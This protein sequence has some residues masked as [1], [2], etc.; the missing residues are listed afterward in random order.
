MTLNAR[1]RQQKLERKKKKRQLVKKTGTMAPGTRDKAR[2]YAKYPVYECLV[3]S[4]IFETGLGTIIVTRRAPSG[5]IAVSAF[6]VDVFCLGVKNAFFKLTSEQDYHGTLKLRLSESLEE[7]QFEN[8]H[9]SCV[10]KLIEGAVD[11]AG[12]LGFAYHPDYKNARELFGDIDAG[13]CPV[14][15]DFGQDGKP[16][17]IQGPNE[18]I[19][20][21]KKI[22][23][24]LEWRCGEGNFHYLLALDAGIDA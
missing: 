11:Y 21:A 20:Q 10:R 9:P 17:Y 3:S 15:Y 4:G 18:S 16:L 2:S 5:E 12:A 14:K 7:Q 8:I 22:V 1:Q 24:K 23:D 6:V 13:A 19:S